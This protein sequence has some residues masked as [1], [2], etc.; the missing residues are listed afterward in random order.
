MHSSILD[1]FCRNLGEKTVNL[2]KLKKYAR[3]PAYKAAVSVMVC[4]IVVHAFGLVNILHNYDNI[5][6][7]PKGYGAGITSG[8]WLLTLLGDFCQN[9][10]DLGYNLPL[11]NGL[12][13]LA[14]IAK[15]GRAHV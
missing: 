11:I 10:L 8:R 9:I 5:L 13:Y 7:Q 15:I 6:Q 4:G 2:N 1:I 12:A 3:S 14:L